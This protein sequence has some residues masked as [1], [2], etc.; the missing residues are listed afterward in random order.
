VSEPLGIARQEIGRRSD[1]ATELLNRYRLPTVLKVYPPPAFGGLIR[2]YNV[3]Q[4][5]IS[6]EMEQD[7]RPSLMEL[8]D[9]IEK[10]IWRCE[11]EMQ[12]RAAKGLDLSSKIGAVPR[13]FRPILGWLF[14]TEKHRV[15]LG[16]VII[17]A[18]VGSC[19][20]I[21]WGFTWKKL[22][23]S[24]SNGCSSKRLGWREFAK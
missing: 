3:F 17:V 8:C 7:A 4:A 15:V 24:S 16:W 20:A 21:S 9:N 2:T 18:L 22:G 11:K 6:L 13:F 5:F 19:C 14:P 10:A 12:E 23:G 1:E